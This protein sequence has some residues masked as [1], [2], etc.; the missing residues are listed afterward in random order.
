MAQYRYAAKIVSRG[1][2]DSAVAKA[3]YNAREDIRDERTGEMKRHA[4]RIG[5]EFSGI[6]APKNVPEWAKDRARLWNAVERK[7][8]ESKRRATAQL[9]RSLELSPAPRVERGAAPPARAGFC[10]R[11]VCQ[12]GHD[13][14]RCDPSPP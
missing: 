2:G 4:K 8:D 14:R 9:A 6:F 12:E 13:C 1:D 10:A 7:E 3:A 11:A 5:L